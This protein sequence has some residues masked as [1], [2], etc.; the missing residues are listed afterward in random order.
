MDPPGAQAAA[1]PA[2]TYFTV[3]SPTKPAKG[4]TALE[5]TYVVAVPPGRWRLQ[6]SGAVSFCLGGPA[7]DV[8]ASEAIFAGGFDAVHPYAPD[9]TLAPA[10]AELADAA[11]AARLKPAD[12]TNG[13]SFACSAL[14]PQTIYVLELPGAPFVA[15]YA[16]G[17]HAN[18]PR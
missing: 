1:L 13:E 11:L 15:G 12:W 4:S 6:G 16:A 14:T 3:S 7:F 8:G 9:M 17:T 2:L 18:P 5:T 10:Q